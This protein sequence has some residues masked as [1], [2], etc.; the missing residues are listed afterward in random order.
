MKV[1]AIAIDGPAGAGK[2]TVA[3]AV[4]K[5]LGFT[6][7]DTGAMYRC[8]ALLAHRHAA[9][10]TDEEALAGIAIAAEIEFEPGDP[11]FVFLNREEVSAAIR[12]PHIGE[13][14]SA[15][16][17]FP[18]VR[19][20]LVA[21]QK[22]ICENGRVVMEGRDTTTVVCPNARLLVFLTASDEERARRRMLELRSKGDSATLVEVLEQIRAR[23]ERDSTRAE[24]P[25]MV[26]PGACVIDTD[27][28]SPDQ[29]V[30]AILDAYQASASA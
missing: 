23:D 25:L 19:K 8:V 18:A 27:S 5:R 28:M 30:E 21:R 22:A 6:F 16:S 24:S 14:A 3:K 2:S 15:I 10:V 11:Q 29:V 9:D 26:A 4:A 7:L 20:S 13:L 17:V 1:D 12:E